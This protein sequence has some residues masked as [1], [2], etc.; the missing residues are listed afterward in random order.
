MST[1]IKKSGRVSHSHVYAMGNNH[2]VWMEALYSWNHRERKFQ[3]V[4]NASLFGARPSKKAGGWQS[5]ESQK[6]KKLTRKLGR[7]WCRNHDVIVDTWKPANIRKL[8]SKDINDWQRCWAM[9]TWHVHVQWCSRA[10]LGTS[11]TTFQSANYLCRGLFQCPF[12]CVWLI[13]D[14][15]QAFSKL[16]AWCVPAATI[17][18]GTV[19]CWRT[20]VSF[21]I[22]WQEW[23]AW[24]PCDI[25][26]F[27]LKPLPRLRTHFIVPPHLAVIWWPS[28]VRF[29]DCVHATTKDRLQETG[30]SSWQICQAKIEQGLRIRVQHG[31]T[32]KSR[33][34]Q[35]NLCACIR[36]ALSIFMP[37]LESQLKSMFIGQCRKRICTQNQSNWQYNQLGFSTKTIVSILCS[38]KY[39]EKRQVCNNC[40]QCLHAFVYIWF[41]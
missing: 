12:L 1:N 38:M 15:Y 29:G 9:G 26:A 25:P 33:Y 27:S 8:N 28:W 17:V 30:R 7:I 36:P 4:D 40:W 34:F 14:W 23:N 24:Q 2:K 11:T 19:L 20:D 18:Q 5:L 22:F 31:L 3:G 39:C 13:D 6:A 37:S 16:S 10:P 21:D 41:L 32:W 35:G